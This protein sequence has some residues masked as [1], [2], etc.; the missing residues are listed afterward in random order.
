M[1]AKI[2]P[3]NVYLPS[4]KQLLN[5]LKDGLEKLHSAKNNS[6]VNEPE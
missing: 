4:E 5:E 3:N 1:L 2:V 6:I